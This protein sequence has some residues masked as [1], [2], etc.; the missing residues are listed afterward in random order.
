MTRGEEANDHLIVSVVRD[1][2]SNPRDGPSECSEPGEH[3]ANLQE[4][5]L[6]RRFAST[7]TNSARVRRGRTRRVV[8]A[9]EPN[10]RVVAG[11]SDSG[12]QDSVESPSLR[13][14]G[15]IADLCRDPAAADLISNGDAGPVR[16][17]RPR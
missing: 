16:N 4:A 9:D 1:Y 12:R 6:T 15:A 17:R 13:Q 14:H 2:R 5:H 3:V 11:Q 7:P 10:R 8:I